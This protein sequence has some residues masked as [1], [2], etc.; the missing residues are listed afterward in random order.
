MIL[1]AAAAEENLT[2]AIPLSLT[3]RSDETSP[4]LEGG[5]ARGVCGYGVGCRV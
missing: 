2:K 5:G 3:A 4:A 1:S